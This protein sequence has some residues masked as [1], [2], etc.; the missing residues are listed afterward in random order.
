MDH[1]E[2]HQREA[3]LPCASVPINCHPQNFVALRLGLRA[4]EHTGGQ[5]GLLRRLSARIDHRM[6]II[7]HEIVALVHRG[8]LDPMI[9]SIT[10]CLVFVAGFVFGY[11]MRAYISHQR[12]R[13]YW[14]RL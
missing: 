7:P 4:V 12:R 5:R 10:I 3:P 9:V 11:G 13:R 14:S 2:G 6:L 1:K 8:L